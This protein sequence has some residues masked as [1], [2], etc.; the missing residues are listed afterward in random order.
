MNPKLIPIELNISS[1]F[2]NPDVADVATTAFPIFSCLPYI[3]PCEL[4]LLT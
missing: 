2:T 3:T 4:K 1:L